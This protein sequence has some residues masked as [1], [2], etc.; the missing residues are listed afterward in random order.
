MVVE[1]RCRHSLESGTANSRGLGWFSPS[2]SEIVGLG[3][4]VPEKLKHFCNCDVE[5]WANFT[6]YICFSVFYFWP[7]VFPYFVRKSLLVC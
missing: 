5:L 7:I 6:A 2:G 1:H 3:D 4:E